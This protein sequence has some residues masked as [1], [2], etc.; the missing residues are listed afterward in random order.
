MENSNLNRSA[1]A[2]ES[3]WLSRARWYHG[4]IFYIII[5]ALSGS[6]LATR[7]YLDRV[8]R[9]PFMPPDWAFGPIW[10]TNQILMITGLIRLARKPAGTPHRKTLLLTQGALWICFALFSWLYFGLHSPIL[11]FLTT[12]GMLLSNAVNLFFGFKMD[13]TYALLYVPLMIWLVLASAVAGW[14][15]FYTPDELFHTAALFQK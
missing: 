14:Q 3:S 7:S 10:V 2:V 11:G 9:P 8:G 6:W 15:V 5:N 4:I 13:R 12:L 1:D